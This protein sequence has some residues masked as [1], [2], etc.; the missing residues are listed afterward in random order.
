[1]DVKEYLKRQKQVQ[2]TQT[3]IRRNPLKWASI[4]EKYKPIRKQKDK[5]RY[6]RKKEENPDFQ[7]EKRR[8]RKLKILNHYSKGTLVCACC[9]E[10]EINFLSLDH[11]NGKHELG[12]DKTYAG[13]KLYEWIIKNDFP[14]G[15]QVL[16]F[17][18]NF[19]KGHFGKCPHEEMREWR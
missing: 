4:K 17:N 2:Y 14:E 9:Q 8:M 3:W 5:E 19:A 11:I 7:N 16:C 10:S 15:F 18:C 1:M 12:H 6:L 13:A